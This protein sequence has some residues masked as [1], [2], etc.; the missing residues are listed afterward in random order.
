MKNSTLQLVLVLLF[1]GVSFHS[2]LLVGRLNNQIAELLVKIDDYE[3]QVN[4]L[5]TTAEIHRTYLKVHM[6][7]PGIKPALATII[8]STVVSQ[9]KLLGENP[10]VY[11][12]LIKTES[13]FNPR[14]VSNV[15]ARGL[16]Q[17]MPQIWGRTICAG[18]NL[19]DPADNIR[20]GTKILAM[21]KELA[22]GNIQSGLS[23][24]WAGPSV[25][26]SNRTITTEYS[27]KVMLEFGKLT[28][29][30]TISKL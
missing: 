1:A 15:G 21:Y 19:F 2:Y 20:C 6:M 12:S 26:R 23:A 16:T 3:S 30:S 10:D 9:A 28:V 25:L 27:N 13:D 11:L 5:T 18:Q 14:A 22:G 4:E 17:V 29:Q 24:Y 7:H 8:S